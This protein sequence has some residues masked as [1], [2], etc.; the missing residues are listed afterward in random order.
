MYLC[1]GDTPL[2]GD[3]SSSE[4]KQTICGSYNCHVH[5]DKKC[6]M[7]EGDRVYEEEKAVSFKA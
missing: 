2:A 7:L 5:G 1:V 3:F 6:W 4:D